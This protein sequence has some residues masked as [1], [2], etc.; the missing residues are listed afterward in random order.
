MGGG[1]IDYFSGKGLQPRNMCSANYA[2]V[3]A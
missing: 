3:V 1:F 2:K